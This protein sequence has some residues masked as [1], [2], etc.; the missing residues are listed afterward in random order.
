MSPK[1]HN[2][3]FAQLNI[4]AIYLNFDIEQKAINSLLE[5]GWAAGLPGFNVTTPYKEVVSELLKSPLKAVNTVYRGEKGWQCA[6]TDGVGFH[7]GLRHIGKELLDFEN[8]IILGAG[9]AARSLIDY[10]QSINYTPSLKIHARKTPP[11]A[12]T[13]A[14]ALTFEKDAINSSLAPTNKTQDSTL[15]IQSTSAPLHGDS[16]EWLTP[17]FKGFQGTFVDLVY[18]NPS[19]I[20]QHLAQIG[21]SCQDGLAMLIE[22]ARESQK[23]WFGQSADYEDIKQ[24]LDRP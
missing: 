24:R 21:A 20:L 5:L 22:Q 9:G 15:V 11:W 8:V 19:H 16:L 1:I 7:M 6:S 4:N 10:F 23:L 12:P 13:W 14:E 3:S 2:H 18:G 17:C